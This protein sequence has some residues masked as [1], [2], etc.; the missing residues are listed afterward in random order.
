VVVAH[1]TAVF[2]EE[3]LEVFGSGSAVALQL[4]RPLP[5]ERETRV[6]EALAAALAAA[7]GS[8]IDAPGL[9]RCDRRLM[10]WGAAFPLAPGLPGELMV[11]PASRVGFCGD[12]V[13]G[14]GFGRIEGALRSGELL[15][16]RWLRAVAPDG[17]ADEACSAPG[18]GV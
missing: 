11:C 5:P 3:H 14:P 1:S 4:G 10:R 12:F 2:A 15:A 13:S 6:I 16:S 18:R 8:R 17:G 9:Q 7:L